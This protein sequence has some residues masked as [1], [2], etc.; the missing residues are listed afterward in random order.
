M[1]ATFHADMPQTPAFYLSVV[2][3]PSN[4]VFWGGVDPGFD[5]IDDTEFMY[6]ANARETGVIGTGL[7]F[8]SPYR[9]PH[10][11]H[12]ID[13]SVAR[14]RKEQARRVA[15]ARRDKRRR[16]VLVERAAPAPVFVAVKPPAPIATRSSAISTTR[17][18]EMA[19]EAAKEW[20]DVMG[21][22]Q[23]ARLFW[24]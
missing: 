8:E 9:E 7:A 18:W 3:Q 17:R 10:I 5:A 20:N 11:P 19:E 16:A 2:E 13:A 6:A 23:P 24:R 22:Q 21:Q 12:F 1:V 14:E 4:E 15:A